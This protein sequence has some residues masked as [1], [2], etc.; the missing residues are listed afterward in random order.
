MSSTQ[1]GRTDVR[2]PTRDYTP[3]GEEQ[4]AGEELLTSLYDRDPCGDRRGGH[5]VVGGQQ[6]ARKRLRERDVLGVGSGEVMAQ[7]PGAIEK[8][9]RR[10][11]HDRQGLQILQCLLCA[12]GADLTLEL[13]AAQDA[14]D[15][16]VE[17]IRCCKRLRGATDAR[18]DIVMRGHVEQAV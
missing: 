5:S 14:E 17:Q 7:P 4:A 9:P 6:H 2:R 15:L 10:I 3:A 8:R 13:P 12:T 16:N 1:P 11:T 18:S